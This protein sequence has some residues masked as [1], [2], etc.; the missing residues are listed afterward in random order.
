M[1][2]KNK[3]FKKN[4]KG[5]DKCSIRAYYCGVRTK[6]NSNTSRKRGK[7]YEEIR[8]IGIWKNMQL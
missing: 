8:N 6:R 3:M 4:K 7:G 1:W 5:I 2:Y